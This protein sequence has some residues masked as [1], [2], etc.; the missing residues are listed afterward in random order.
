MNILNDARGFLAPVDAVAEAKQ[1]FLL[2]S[3]ALEDYINK[4]GLN[5]VQAWTSLSGSTS[6]IVC[7]ALVSNLG[8]DLL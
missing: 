2:L 8:S 1:Q 5:S 3:T 4:V 7:C 6:W